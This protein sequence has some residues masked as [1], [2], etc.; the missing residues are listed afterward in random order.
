MNRPLG[1]SYP[2]GVTRLPWEDVDVTC[3]VCLGDPESSD[4][5]SACICPEC[6]ICGSAGDP[7]C[8]ARGTR[9]NHALELRPKHRPLVAERRR[10]LDELQR[11]ESLADLHL[12][13]LERTRPAGQDNP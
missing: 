6:N 4:P 7:A 8:Y 13:R 9:T 3:E 10:R 5:A 11:Q 1:W 12:A 2:A